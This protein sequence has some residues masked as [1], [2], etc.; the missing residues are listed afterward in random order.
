MEPH[1]AH[2]L[3]W[4]SLGDIIKSTRTHENK[5]FKGTALD[6]TKLKTII[7]FAKCLCSALEEFVATDTSGDEENA[8][9]DPQNW[10]ARAYID[11]YH[12]LGYYSSIIWGYVELNL[13]LSDAKAFEPLLLRETGRRMTQTMESMRGVHWA[14][15]NHSMRLAAHF[16]QA[17]DSQGNMAPLSAD[18]CKILRN[19][20]AMLFRCMYHLLPLKGGDL[21]AE[22]V[23]KKLAERFGWW[24]SVMVY[25]ESR[26]N[27]V[28]ATLVKENSDGDSEQRN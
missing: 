5:S 3:P 8:D 11:N 27:F 26:K 13:L 9:L 28:V 16:Q 18:V 4:Q 6:R 14:G 15:D 19:H 23:V 10:D 20:A 24:D 25:S 1:L 17:F 7:H 2:R 21:D 12:G 22:L